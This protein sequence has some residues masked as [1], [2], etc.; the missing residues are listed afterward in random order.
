MGFARLPESW[1]AKLIADVRRVLTSAAGFFLRIAYAQ[2]PD[3]PDYRDLRR[4]EGRMLE[5]QLHSL[6]RG[7]RNDLG[8]LIASFLAYPTHVPETGQAQVEF[9]AGLA[10]LFDV[11]RTEAAVADLERP[12]DQPERKAPRR[13]RQPPEPI[14]VDLD[15]KGNEGE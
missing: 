5:H 15:K 8:E 2:N 3:D 12:P 4:L 7:G 9:F 1:L 14:W 10:H 11:E 6:F 13:K